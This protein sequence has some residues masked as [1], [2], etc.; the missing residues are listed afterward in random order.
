[1]GKE[2]TA[3]EWR[4]VIAKDLD[5][6]LDKAVKSKDTDLEAQL[7]KE[8]PVSKSFEDLKLY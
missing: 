5:E 6:G 7:R 1:M 4:A 2:L 3:R 8:I